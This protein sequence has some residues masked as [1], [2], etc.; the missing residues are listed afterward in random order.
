MRYLAATLLAGAA[1]M[2]S[3]VAAAP[4]GKDAKADESWSVEA[5]KG[6]VIKQVPISTEEGTW[7]DVD[8]S[9]DGQTLAFTLLGDIYTMPITGGTPTRISEGLSWDVQPRF[10]PDGTRIAFTSDRGGGDNIWVMNRDGSDKRQVT[11]EDF[12]LLNQPAWSP[13]GRYIAAKKHFTTER[14]AGTGE[15]WLYHVSGGGGVQVVERANE[16]LQKELGEPVFAPDGSAI[17]YTRNTTGGNVFDYAQD[18]NAGIFAIERKDLATGEVT[19]AVSGYGGAV[20]P[21]PSP[22]GKQIAFVRR[23][24]DQTQLWV[25]DLASGREAMVFGKLDL[26]VQE[27]WAVT[28]VYPNI[29]WLPDSSAIIFWAG[30]KLNRVNRDGTGHAV[31]PFKVNDTRAVANAPHPVI[32]VAPETFTTTM[33]RFAMLSP[34]GAS[35]VFETLGKLHTKSA[36]GKDLPRPLTGDSADVIEAFPAFSRDGGA[37][38]Y[39][40]WSDDKLGEIVLADA[41]GQNRRV[42]VG[43]GHYG[44]LAFSP[45]GAMIAFEK[46]EGGYLTSPDFSQDPGVYVMPVAGGEPR[47]VTRD[48]ANPQW[49]AASDRLFMLGREDG[50]LALVSTDLN[51]EAKRVHAKGDLANDLRIAP[52]GRT[53]A[54]RQNYEVF[55]MPL[56][57]G[58]KPVDVSES[59]GSLP[60]TKVSTGGADYLGWARGGETLFWS[61]GPSLQSANVSELFANAP[62]A[63]GDKTAAYTPPTTG[64]PLGVTVQKAKPTG[65][66]V[67]TGARVL[68]MRAGL[69]ADDAGVI[70]NGMIVIEGDR[71]T[72]V[73]DATT[74]KIAFPEGTRFIDASG[75]T[76]MPGLVDAHAHG[77][78]GVGDL[79][80]Q[81]NWTLLQDL[82]LGVTTVHNPSSQASTVFAAAER[83]R[84]GL[85]T[86]PRIFSTG[87]IIYGAKAPDVYARID[88]YEDALAHVR[89]IKAQGGISVKNYNQP[90]REQRQMV[91][92]AAAAENMLVVAEGGSLFGMDMN[93]VADGNST[94]EHNV[95]VDVFYNDVLQFFGQANTN[96]TPTLVVTY[97]GLAGDPYWRQATNVWENPLMVHTPPKMLLADTGRRTTAPD[98]AFVDDNNAREARKLAQRGVKVSI[99]AHGQQAG[100]GAHWELWSFARGGMSSVEALKAGTI[101]SAQSLGMAKDIGSI[102][103]GKLADLVILSADPSKD[104]AN[105]DNIEQVM[106]G[107]RLYDAKTMNETGTG[108]AARHPYWWEAAGGKGAGG[109]AEATAAGR[110][111]ADGDAG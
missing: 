59:G 26:D 103:A 80:P 106:L 105:S 68:T 51:G 5:P 99:G 73:H 46:R 17:Y 10:S 64:I 16:R 52:D 19:T 27:T 95:P 84:A 50:G 9:P 38:A 40:R 34:D 44:N 66:T 18:S 65:T 56:V 107:G 87:E 24:K 111:H 93:I 88:S 79:I 57:P 86:G 71:I 14:S 60:V 13:D 31:I 47:L 75:K 35:V 92:R 72:G 41:Q 36:R 83:Q 39:V 96:Y 3:P 104:I 58:G 98:W 54:F 25:K 22:D 8:V 97:G 32:E 28:G 102:E 90:R 55:A 29:D 49:G 81:Q 61:I 69:A 37:L 30:G 1:V 74:V 70:E 91:V 109:S 53:I 89:R 67:I 15:I 77:A 101:T 42:L 82:A 85:T 62:K 2:A 11:K 43:P 21:A 76:I 100:I 6:A 110:G 33:P 63:E 94:L 23:D 7:M 108:T 4:K 20:R 12:R 45:D 48:G 78:Y